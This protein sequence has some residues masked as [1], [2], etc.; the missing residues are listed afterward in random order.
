MDQEIDRLVVINIPTSQKF[1]AKKLEDG[2]YELAGNGRVVIVTAHTF[3][4]LYLPEEI[5]MA[6]KLIAQQKM[7]KR[8]ENKQIM[9][10]R[11][12]RRNER[13]SKQITAP[14]PKSNAPLPD[15]TPYEDKVCDYVMEMTDVMSEFGT[16]ERPPTNGLKRMEWR[17]GIEK[18]RR[19]TTYVKIPKW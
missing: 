14:K 11:E 4:S 12:I 2:N 15:L 8:I 3:N 17:E 16:F 13:L 1:L 9:K 18:K 10:M 7:A 5:W 6:N 19:K